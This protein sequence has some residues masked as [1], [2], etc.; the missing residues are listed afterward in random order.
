MDLKVSQKEPRLQPSG[1]VEVLV[2]NVFDL[3][4]VFGEDDYI[5]DVA[6]LDDDRAELLDRAMFATV[7]QRGSDPLEPGDG[8]QLAEAVIGEVSTLVIITQIQ[9]VVQ[10]EGPGVR[11]SYEMLRAGGSE[12]LSVKVTLTG[13]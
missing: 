7:K 10:K 3:Y 12:Y 2:S 4:P 13:V 1:A 5:M 8:I 11:A 6:V 9:A